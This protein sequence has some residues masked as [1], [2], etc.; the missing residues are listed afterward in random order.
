MPAFFEVS[1]Q[2][3]EY[4]ASIFCSL[5]SL[6]IFFLF[7][8][9]NKTR[10]STLIFYLEA[11]I[12]CYS[13]SAFI[14]WIF[15]TIWG[16]TRIQLNTTDYYSLITLGSDIEYLSLAIGNVFLLAFVE[17]VYYEKN[18]TKFIV[19][20][21]KLLAILSIVAGMMSVIFFFL[22]LDTV[23]LLLI[24]VFCSILIYTRLTLN[25]FHLRK[26]LII[27]NPSSKVEIHSLNYMGISGIVLALAI[28]AFVVHE[29]INV[30][31]APAPNNEWID[32]S[33]GWLLAALAGVLIYLGYII[34]DWIRKMWEV[35]P[36]LIA[37]N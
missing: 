35:D 28:A 37:V 30:I 9:R 23:L 15:Y 7:K 19:I 29:V 12:F 5:I 17:K 1:Y 27:D 4:S 24:L 34:P 8:N 36:T 6:G 3:M 31:V 33:A 25:S 10:Q 22:N 32:V 26:K 13:L 2:W 16:L 14:D 20:F 11:A 18:A 21:H